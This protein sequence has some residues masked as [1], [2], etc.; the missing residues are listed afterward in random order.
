MIQASQ[1]VISLLCLELWILECL[2]TDKHN[3]EPPPLPQH[4]HTK[5]KKKGGERWDHPNRLLKL[6]LIVLT[7]I[8]AFKA[9]IYQSESTR[10]IGTVVATPKEK[11][12]YKNTSFS[13]T[14]L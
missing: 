3:L 12:D 9:Y 14:Y 7:K 13:F 5:G 10:H 8:S 1:I 11:L 4:T 6:A 2:E